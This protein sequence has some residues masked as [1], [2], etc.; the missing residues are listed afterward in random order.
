M[1]FILIIALIIVFPKKQP[2]HVI[3]LRQSTETGHRTKQ[4]ISRSKGTCQSHKIHFYHC[5]DNHSYKNT[6]ET[7]NLITTI[8]Q[9]SP[10]NETN[11]LTT[12]VTCK[13]CEISFS[14][15][16]L[17][18]ILLKKQTK[19]V[20]LLQQ[21]TKTDQIILRPQIPAKFVEVVTDHI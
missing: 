19:R 7:R 5:I 9:I 15:I 18:V 20:I 2:K 13:N 10:Q 16:V 3:Q 21:S 6:T 8:N 12:K 17:T 11:D 4:T 14:I 1:T